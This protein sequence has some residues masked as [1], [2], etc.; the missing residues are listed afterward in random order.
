MDDACD[1]VVGDVVLGEPEQKI[2]MMVKLGSKG[3]LEDADESCTT[4]RLGFNDGMIVGRSE[5]AGSD[6][7][8]KRRV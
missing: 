1:S 5:T 2:M 7:G 6:R 4:I 8:G 3:D